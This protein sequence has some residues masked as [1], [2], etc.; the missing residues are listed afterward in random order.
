MK[1]IFCCSGSDRLGDFFVGDSEGE[2][3]QVLLF[4][5]RAAAVTCR[6][7]K[8]TRW[9][10]LM[11]NRHGEAL[12]SQIVKVEIRVALSRSRAGVF[13][14]DQSFWRGTAAAC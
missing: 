9:T 7:I 13:S 1:S 5:R 2:Q 10:G 11:A 3:I 12:A 14:R 8:L 4:A 6:H